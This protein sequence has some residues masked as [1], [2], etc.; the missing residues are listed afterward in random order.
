LSCHQRCLRGVVLGDHQEPARVAVEA[1]DDAGPCDARDAA[2]VVAARA[3]RVDERP[4]PVAG[5]RVDHEAGRLVDD[6]QVL[7]LVDDVDRDLG[8]RGDL[9]R[10]DRR[11]VE[12][13][14]G[15]QL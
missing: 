4:A 3:E 6:Q 2:V 13:E 14:L 11:D 8:R 10:D 9:R 12:L 5:R 15:P 7:V 1:V